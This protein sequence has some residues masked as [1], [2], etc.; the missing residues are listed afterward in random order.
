MGAVC[1]CLSATDQD[2]GGQGSCEW[3]VSSLKTLTELARLGVACAQYSCRLLSMMLLSTKPKAAAVSKAAARQAGLL[4]LLLYQMKLWGE[5][6][7]EAPGVTTVSYAAL[8]LSRLVTGSEKNHEL[9]REHGGLELLVQLLWAYHVQVGVKNAVWPISAPIF[10]SMSRGK[11]S[12]CTGE[13]TMEA[14]GG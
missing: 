8:A 9:L 3:S 1:E 7:Q 6:E 4:E 14:N 5:S 13:V 10:E 11:A 12:M 2:C